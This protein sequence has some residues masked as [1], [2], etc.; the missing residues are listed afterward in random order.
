[1]SAALV[2]CS[3]RLG[4]SWALNRA[5][6]HDRRVRQRL[7]PDGEVLCRW[8][9]LGVFRR[10]IGRL[11]NRDRDLFRAGKLGLPGWLRRL[12]AATA[13]ATAGTRLGKP[14]DVFYRFVGREL[15]VVRCGC[16]TNGQKRDQDEGQMRPDRCRSS[17]PRLPI[18]KRKAEID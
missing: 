11:R 2:T 3:L 12:V 5:W 17:D 6:Q 14:D 4:D 10:W 9:F 18:L 15:A 13:A 1:A 8:W 7:R 16:E